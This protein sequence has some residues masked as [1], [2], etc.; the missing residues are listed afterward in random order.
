[1][2]KI[3]YSKII[4]NEN[5]NEMRIKPPIYSGEFFQNQSFFSFLKPNIKDDSVF[6]EYSF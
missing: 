2:F 3:K 5:E 1:M 6:K 4:E